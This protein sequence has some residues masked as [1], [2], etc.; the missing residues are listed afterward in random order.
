MIYPCGS[1]LVM[2]MYSV[3][4]VGFIV[5]LSTVVVIGRLR[6]ITLNI[7]KIRI[8]LINYSYPFT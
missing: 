1:L 5:V 3:T 4:T 8:N 6:N 2:V 7:D